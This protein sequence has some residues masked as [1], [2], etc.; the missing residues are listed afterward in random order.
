MTRF[1]L[2]TNVV[3]ELRKTKP[4]SAVLE[5][6]GG[7]ANEQIFISSVTFGEIQAGVKRT[8]LQDARKAIEIDAWI[9]Q[10]SRVY[11]VLP[12]DTEC[13]LEWGRLKVGKPDRILEDAMIAAVARIHDLVVATRNE[14]DF[15]R[16]QVRLF[17]PFTRR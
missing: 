1:L 13:F 6:L 4:H 9:V 15:D 16:L 10:L 7:L 17:N 14:R 11:R 8:R 2:D 5:W 3:S 12:M